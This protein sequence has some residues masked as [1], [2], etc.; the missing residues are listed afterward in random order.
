LFAALPGYIN[1]ILSVVLY[2]RDT[3]LLAGEF[4]QYVFWKLV[5]AGKKAGSGPSDKYLIN[6]FPVEQLGRWT[7]KRVATFYLKLER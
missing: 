2:G 5:P 4:N 1:N 6:S 7:P 3:P